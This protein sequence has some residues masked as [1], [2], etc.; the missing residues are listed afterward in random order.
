MKLWRNTTRR[1]PVSAQNSAAP[2]VLRER[3]ADRAAD[4]RAEH[5]RDRGVAQPRLEDHDQRAEQP[6]PNADVDGRPVAEAAA[7]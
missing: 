4:Q 7:A 6:T 3:Q 2:I 5:V 1:S